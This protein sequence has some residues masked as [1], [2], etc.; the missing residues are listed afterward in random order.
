MET[1]YGTQAAPSRV[2]K[3]SCVF[4]TTDTRRYDNQASDGGL[5][6]VPGRILLVVPSVLNLWTQLL[7]AGGWLWEPDFL[8]YLLSLFVYLYASG[9]MFVIIILYRPGDEYTA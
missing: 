3:I 2:G 6:P 7:N 1:A 8:A 4:R 5:L 9:L